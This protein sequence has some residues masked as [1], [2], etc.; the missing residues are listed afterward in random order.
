MFEAGGS[1]ILGYGVQY[2]THD[3]QT[4]TATRVHSLNDVLLTGAE[5]SVH[6]VSTAVF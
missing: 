5:T 1:L 6:C 4:Y 2:N 3:S